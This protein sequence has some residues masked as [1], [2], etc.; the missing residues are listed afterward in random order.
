[1]EGA[2]DGSLVLGV[3][4][5]WQAADETNSDDNAAHRTG[6]SVKWYGR[7]RAE[8]GRKIPLAA[9][10]RMVTPRAPSADERPWRHAPPTTARWT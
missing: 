5:R 9:V 2:I 1:M 6:L 10:D 7:L 3:Y 8:P 4:E